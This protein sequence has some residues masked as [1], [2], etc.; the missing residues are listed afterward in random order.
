MNNKEDT[1]DTKD[2]K[3]IFGSYEKSLSD[4]KVLI[5]HNDT[6]YMVGGNAR[7]NLKSNMEEWA[8]VLNSDTKDQIK[9]INQILNIPQQITEPD[10]L[11]LF[12]QELNK[13]QN[14]EFVKFME[15]SLNLYEPIQ[16]Q[17][18]KLFYVILDKF[19]DGGKD[20]K[21]HIGFCKFEPITRITQLLNA[22]NAG[23]LAVKVTDNQ[24]NKILAL[25]NTI[26]AII[27]SKQGNSNF[28]LGG[29]PI[30]SK[31]DLRS[32]MNR[33]IE[34]H[35]SLFP[36]LNQIEKKNIEIAEN[37]EALSIELKGI[38]VV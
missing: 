21:Y 19:T 10:E 9:A 5:G 12:L 33:I 11:Y 18:R 27:D 7:Y 1:K 8:L 34:S 32:L 24:F 4:S 23:D 31:A 3:E 36:I 14:D 29:A 16:I 20:D 25:I 30:D 17:L 2:T 6:N 37:L 35:K 13:L 15:A 38:N 22:L 28:A 26:K